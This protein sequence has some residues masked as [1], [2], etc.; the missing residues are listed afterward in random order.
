VITAF[1]HDR[2]SLSCFFCALLIRNPKK[3]LASLVGTE[4]A[5]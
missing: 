2:I 4:L 5:A 1:K 3:D